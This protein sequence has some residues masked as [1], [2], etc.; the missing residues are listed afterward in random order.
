MDSLPIEE[1]NRILDQLRAKYKAAAEK[2][3]SHY[4]NQRDLEARIT[5]LLRNR[6]SLTRFLESE[7]EFF[8]TLRDKALADLE[9]EKKRAE[10]HERMGKI[11]R[12]NL[13]KIQKYPA[14]RFSS[15]ASEEI[16]HFVGAI[17]EFMN[18]Y[19]DIL[20]HLFRGKPEWPK[21]SEK[22]GALERYHLP[23]DL[24]ATPFLKHYDEQVRGLGIEGMEELDR[25]VMQTGGLTIYQLILELDK[26]VKT[27][28]DSEK[29]EFI[30][31]LPHE[32][33]PFTA[34]EKEHWKERRVMDVVN[35]ARFYLSGILDDFRIRQLVEHAY[36]E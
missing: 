30:R 4:F 33:T 27:M 32:R 9:E 22:L 14:I 15:A 18:R 5:E 24:Q 21:M 12:E 11:M 6:G 35:E 29:K 26:L 2:Y 13:E 31:F 28:P 1:R 17:T 25:K 20:T 10:F 19:Y 7:M 23:P 3:G 34:D 36:R 16:Q 8:N